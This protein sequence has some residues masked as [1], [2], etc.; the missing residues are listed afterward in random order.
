MYTLSLEFK[1]VQSQDYLNKL[2]GVGLV[3]NRPSTNLLH[4]F[5]R[6]KEEKDELFFK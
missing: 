5:I 6:K 1:I 2:D 4:T 3:D